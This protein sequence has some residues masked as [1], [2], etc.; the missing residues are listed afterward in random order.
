M[1]ENDVSAL[2]WHF[3][4]FCVCA[5]LDRL[6][7]ASFLLNLLTIKPFIRVCK[8]LPRDKQKRVACKR[9][10]RYADDF[11]CM[12]RSFRETVL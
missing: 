6:F 7:V 1:D 10:A 9:I 5:F 4:F 11:D 8:V 3:G 12:P 2:P